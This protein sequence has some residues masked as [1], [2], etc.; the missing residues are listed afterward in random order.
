MPY[1][2]CMERYEENNI[3]SLKYLSKK[4]KASVVVMREINNIWCSDH[5]FRNRQRRFAT[6]FL[7][8]WIAVHTDKYINLSPLCSAFYDMTL[9]S[10]S[11]LLHN[12]TQLL[13]R[14]A[15][16]LFNSNSVPSL[17]SNVSP[18]PI[19][20]LSQWLSLAALL[21]HFFICHN[22]YVQSRAIQLPLN[23]LKDDEWLFMLKG[24]Q[25]TS[26]AADRN[27]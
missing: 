9:C 2:G 1:P 25:A 23:L 10:S 15:P 14:S 27:G 13:T 3:Q 21:I 24:P 7:C 4:K 12:E 6:Q 18:L 17:T 11:V 16:A 5:P 19:P 8:K 26:A 20:H 22:L